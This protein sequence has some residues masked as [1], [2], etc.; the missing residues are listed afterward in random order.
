MSTEPLTFLEFALIAIMVLI[1]LVYW[2]LGNILDALKGSGGAVA[3]GAARASAPMPIAGKTI[4]PGLSDEKFIAIIS[5]A[6]ASALGQPVNV[7]GFK[8]LSTMD[9]TWAVQ[10]RVALHKNKV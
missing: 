8:P 1:G 2:R 4:H 3:T 5:A 7:V 6:T 10:G 9:W